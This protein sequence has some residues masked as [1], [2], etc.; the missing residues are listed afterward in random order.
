MV[1]R[2]ARITNGCELALHAPGARH[3]TPPPAV[4]LAGVTDQVAERWATARDAPEPTEAQ[5]AE[6]TRHDTETHRRQR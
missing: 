5:L 1:R 2:L 3:A 4:P 6:A